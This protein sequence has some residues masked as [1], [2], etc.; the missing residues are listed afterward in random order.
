MTTFQVKLANQ[1]TD[2]VTLLKRL[3]LGPS[4]LAIVREKAELLHQG[5]LSRGEAVLPI[6]LA[7]FIFDVLCPRSGG[8]HNKRQITGK[9]C[10][11]TKEDEE[12]G[13]KA[14][15]YALGTVQCSYGIRGSCG[16]VPHLNTSE[17][18][19]SY[20]GACATSPQRFKEQWRGGHVGAP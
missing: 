19:I 1:E 5:Q 3:P 11:T 12:L 17:A 15:L 13:F 9:L 4:E 6:M 10:E 14:A 7:T 20:Y 2:L 16:K 8:S 18:L